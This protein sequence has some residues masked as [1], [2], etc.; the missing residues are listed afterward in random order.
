M[1]WD[2]CGW[3]VLEYNYVDGGWRAVGSVWVVGGVLQ[4]MGVVS[5]WVLCCGV[6]VVCVSVVL[7]GMCV[8]CAAGYV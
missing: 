1:L 5:V 6:C 8:C 4:G 2:M 7:W 3:W